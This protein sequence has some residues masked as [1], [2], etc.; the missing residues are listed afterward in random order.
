MSDFTE[1]LREL[2]A[3]HPRTTVYEAV[4]YGCVCDAC[5]GDLNDD[6]THME[7]EWEGEFFCLDSPLSVSC[8]TCVDAE[9]NYAKWP[10]PTGELI[11]KWEKHLITTRLTINPVAE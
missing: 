9:G 4:G 1:L 5:G 3:Q 11:E 6:S 2:R 7:G 8:G 10:C